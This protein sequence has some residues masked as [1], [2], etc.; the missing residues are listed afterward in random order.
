GG[1]G[2]HVDGRGVGA[3]VALLPHP[4]L[5][6]GADRGRRGHGGAG[7]GAEEAVGDHV[8]GGQ[9]GR[10]P[11]GH[12]LGGVDEP[13]GDATGVHQRPGEDE[14]GDGQQREAVGAGEHAL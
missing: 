13:G 14:E 10:Q 8:G 5:G 6:D 3:V 1:G 11:P 4:R 2:G 9:G 12:H 7:H